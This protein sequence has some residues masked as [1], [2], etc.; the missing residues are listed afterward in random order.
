[1]ALWDQLGVPKNT[2]IFFFIIL[3]ATF[4]IGF[5]TGN[6]QSDVPLGLTKSAD[7]IDLS[8]VTKPI[9]VY[10]CGEIKNP[11]VYEMASGDCVQTVVEKA[12]GFKE[13][14]DKKTI[15]LART[16]KGG[17]Q[18][19]IHSL[20]LLNDSLPSL[21]PGTKGQS[22]SQQKSSLININTA[23]KELLMNLPGIGEVKA[24]AIIAY[25]DKNGWFSEVEELD[26]VSGIGPKT[27]ETLLPLITIN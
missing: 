21:T 17:E 3:L 18:I 8:Q 1:M 16:L 26:K 14:A 10:I 24:L 19:T 5:L 27:L 9:K 7:I 4:G 12:G 13:Q 23:T 11:G 20:V 22:G 2:F 15:N 6:R 25:R